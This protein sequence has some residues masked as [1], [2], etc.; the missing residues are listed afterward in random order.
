MDILRVLSGTFILSK[1]S[2]VLDVKSRLISAN[3]G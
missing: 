1:N 3:L 2:R